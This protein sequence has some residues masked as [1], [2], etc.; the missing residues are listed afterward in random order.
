MLTSNLTTP[1]LLLPIVTAA[2]VL[3]LASPA[4][5]QAKA[6][7]KKKKKVD[8]AVLAGTVMNQAEEILA[9]VA[10]E[11]SLE[12]AGISESAV[13]DKQG[14]FS[15]E[16]P[17][18]GEYQL[19]LSKEGFAT[20]EELIFLA[21]GE[22]QA[23]QIKLLDAAA[24]RRSDAVKAYNAGA[25][26]YRAKD[27]ATAKKHFLAA[28]A[29]DPAL[30][31][32]FL[33]LADIYM[34]ESA[35]AEAAAA[36]ERFLE[37]KPGDQKGQMLAYEAYLKLGNQAKLEELRAVLAKTDVAPKLAIQIYNEGA[38]ADQKG[39]VDAAIEKFRGALDLDPNLVEARAGLATV[40]Y[41]AGRFD[42]ALAS[43]EAL[44]AAK[45]DHANGHR[46]RFLIQDGRGDR[47]GAD[48]AMQSYIGIDPKGASGL[49]FKR[50]D[51]DF[52]AGEIDIAR[53]AFH[54]VLELDP[55]N[56]R[57]HYSLG[58]IYASTDTAK[59]KQHLLKFIEM[60]PED[61]EVGSAKEMLSYF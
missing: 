7:K 44:L 40:Y 25:E 18:E 59:A 6:K 56:A 24:G 11:V 3:L 54:K 51:L 5:L 36:A 21:L 41:R 52:R 15:V 61:P 4:D 42:E 34:V 49:L 16:L 33:V 31:E 32:P 9:G 23:I 39:D 53:G 12:T 37:L 43:V 57:A 8:H 20:R 35:P 46:L 60:A 27:M 2:L 14:E 10:V 47:E 50:A 28:T 19:K 17:A 26:A 29:A 13:T 38:L 22:Q 30:A 58:K 48:A 1:R 45:A 55:E